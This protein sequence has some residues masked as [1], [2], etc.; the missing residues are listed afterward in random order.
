MKKLIILLLLTGSVKADDLLFSETFDISYQPMTVVV[1]Y[2]THTWAS[3]QCINYNGNKF[4][5][6]NTP[7]AYI[8][9]VGDVYFINNKLIYC[10]GVIHPFLA[11]LDCTNNQGN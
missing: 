4:K 8:S 5:C 6:P 1:N 9:D 3:N 2:P 11:S 7:Q 10:I